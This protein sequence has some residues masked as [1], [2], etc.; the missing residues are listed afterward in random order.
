MPATSCGVSAFRGDS[1]PF[2]NALEGGAVTPLR[3]CGQARRCF[4]KRAGGSLAEP[5]A[6]E[7]ERVLGATAGPLARELAL[8][9]LVAVSQPTQR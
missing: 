6:V 9:L 1:P 4:A 5:R 2:V 8:G 7:R 3:G